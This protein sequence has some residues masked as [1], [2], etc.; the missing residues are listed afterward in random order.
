MGIN[1][2]QV[3]VIPGQKTMTSGV[4]A[5]QHVVV[6]APDQSEAWALIEREM[7]EFKALG[8]TSLKEY[9]D[10]VVKIRATLSGSESDWSMLVHPEFG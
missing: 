4:A 8:A 10:A 3:F 5:I 1:T 6:V 2:D 7:P 9:E